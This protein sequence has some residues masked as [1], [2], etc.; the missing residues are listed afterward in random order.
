M[1]RKTRLFFGVLFGGLV[2]GTA[3]LLVALLTAEGRAGE[4]DLFG[5]LAKWALILL[6]IA[7]SLPCFLADFLAVKGAC[8]LTEGDYETKTE[9]IADI[10]SLSVSTVQIL[11]FATFCTVHLI[12]PSALSLLAFKVFMAVLWACA[13]I[14]VT[15]EIERLTD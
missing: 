6:G 5:G 1:K 12:A 15:I 2:I 14:T 9:R 7:F 10:V 4:R 13:A 3:A 11:A 8:L